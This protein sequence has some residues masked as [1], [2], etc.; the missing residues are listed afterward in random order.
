MIKKI[1]YAINILKSPEKELKKLDNILLDTILGKYL[2]LL[3]ISSIFSSILI[4]LIRILR[5]VYFDIFLNTNVDYIGLLN[6]SAGYAVSLFFLYL[7]IGTIG[8]FLISVVIKLIFSKKKF[9]NI[10]KLLLISLT[11]V[12]LFLWIPTAAPYLLIWSLF[13][14]L[15]GI[16]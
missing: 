7:F 16:K 2:I 12:I 8:L 3:L 10:I 15:L 9:V 1:K 13:I 6:Y 4:F 5:S 14:F 11:P